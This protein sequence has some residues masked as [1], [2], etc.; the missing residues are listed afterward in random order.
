MPIN[1]EGREEIKFF[2]PDLENRAKKLLGQNIC[3]V[4]QM[5][6]YSQK[7]LSISLG[8]SPNAIS[9]WEL[10]NSSP[11]IDDLLHICA[12][13]KISPNDLLGWGESPKLKEYRKQKEQLNARMEELKKQKKDIENQIKVISDKLDRK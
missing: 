11:S 6:G 8:K 12:L 7:E 13:F 5:N 10:G 2:P 1:S 4:R 3:L 9:S